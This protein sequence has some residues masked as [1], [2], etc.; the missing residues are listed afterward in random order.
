MYLRQAVL[1][2]RL[3]ETLMTLAD[4]SFAS[5]G[6]LREG[7]SREELTGEE[8]AEAEGEKTGEEEEEVLARRLGLRT[9]TDDGAPFAP[10]ADTTQVDSLTAIIAAAAPAA[11]EYEHELHAMRAQVAAAAAAQSAL[12]IEAAHLRDEL[13]AAAA[14][15]SA[16]EAAHRAVCE[17]HEGLYR[18][19]QALD[20]EQGTW[21]ALQQ[22][23]RVA[24]EENVR[25]RAAD[26]AADDEKGV[27]R[28]LLPLLIFSLP[29]FRT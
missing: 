15:R 17:E 21:A 27:C 19:W 18:Q 4:S 11:L 20:A 16:L 25:L 7:L 6:A 22:T 8:E 1:A 14:S 9:D 2:T 13:G 29:S 23:H 5:V 26:D 3:E 28:A 24:V 12:E 10:D